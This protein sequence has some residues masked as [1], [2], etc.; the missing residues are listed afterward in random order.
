MAAMKIPAHISAL[1][2]HGAKFAKHGPMAKHA[3]KMAK[4]KASAKPKR[5]DMT[6]SMYEPESY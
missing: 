4:P 6:G 5:A 2:K 1:A 3:A